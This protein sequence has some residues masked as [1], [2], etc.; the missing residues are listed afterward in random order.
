MCGPREKHIVSE[1]LTE[2]KGSKPEL[3]TF[4]RS[5]ARDDRLMLHLGDHAPSI[6]IL[7]TSK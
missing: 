4:P 2:K 6:I 3:D 5:A 7:S 1:R